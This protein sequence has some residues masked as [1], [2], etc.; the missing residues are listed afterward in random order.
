LSALFSLFLIHGAFA[1]TPSTGEII[2]PIPNPVPL[3]DEN[4]PSMFFGPITPEQA[5]AY[6]SELQRLRLE[7]P[8]AEIEIPDPAPQD[9]IA[10][11]VPPLSWTEPDGSVHSFAASS[12]LL[13][14]I[15]EQRQ[16][17]DAL[18]TLEIPTEKRLVLAALM[19][20]ISRQGILQ[21]IVLYSQLVIYLDGIGADECD[22]APSAC[23]NPDY[24][25]GSTSQKGDLS[26]L[27]HAGYDY[28]PSVMWD[29]G[30]YKMWWCSDGTLTGDHIFYAEST[31]L[32]SWTILANGNQ[33][34]VFS[35]SYNPA[36]DNGTK[37]KFDSLLTCDPSVVKVGGTYFMYYT[38]YPRNNGTYSFTTRIGAAYSYDGKQW[39][40]Y[41]N[42]VAPIINTHVSGVSVFGTPPHYGVGHP[43]VVY[44]DGFF[45][46]TYNDSSGASGGGTTQY[47]LRS[48]DPFFQVNVEEWRTGGVWYRLNGSPGSTGY[49]YLNPGVSVDWAYSPASK[50]FVISV[51]GAG[52]TYSSG[53]ESGRRGTY[54]SIRVFNKALTSQRDLT[55][56][57]AQWVDGP[58]IVKGPSGHMLY[59]AACEN[60]L[61]RV[62]RAGR[63]WNDP[64]GIYTHSQCETNYH[65]SLLPPPTP[66]PTPDPRHIAHQ[67]MIQCTELAYEGWDMD[68][69]VT[70]CNSL[71]S[72]SLVQ[73]ESDDDGVSDPVVWRP[74]TG[75]WWSK[76]ST[77]SGE[78]GE[79]WGS[80]TAQPIFGADY[81]GDR[82]AD[83][84]VKEGPHFRVRPS[85]G[86]CPYPFVPYVGTKG[87]TWD[88]GWATADVPLPGDYD[89]DGKTDMAV[90]I[91]S[92][93]KFQYIRTGGACRSSYSA[94]NISGL[95]GCERSMG[96]SG[97]K[98]IVADYDGD[99]KADFSYVYYSGSNPAQ[100]WTS[101]IS[102]SSCPS[103]FSSLFTNCYVQLA[104]STDVVVTADLNDDGKTDI[105]WWNAADYTFRTRESSSTTCPENFGHASG[106]CSLAMGLSGDVPL[107]KQFN[108]NTKPEPVVWRPSNGTW[109]VNRTG[110]S[111]PIGPWTFHYASGPLYIHA[112]QWGLSSDKVEGLR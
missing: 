11:P 19:S 37:N 100:I 58:G 112:S 99:G 16:S 17:H 111:N 76:R 84:A 33:G 68:S 94:V 55:H 48:T 108:G 27:T 45:Y 18:A 103:G 21:S 95:G 29:E 57:R 46:I 44:L 34:I 26:V 6:S 5:Q 107:G 49:P 87:C 70:G 101:P 88:T 32:T 3:G 80:A 62:L 77:N 105:A 73:D 35:P 102:G 110:S 41:N 82:I 14:F 28:V 74:S 63:D 109:Y 23:R 104:A 85:S 50:E 67:A 83:L 65:S 8:D 30:K 20:A 64:K 93:A 53:G 42:G 56:V 25:Q 2:Q 43:S 81:D 36:D 106:I 24:G 78:Q 1:E 90:R 15:S 79:Q 75:T 61:I 97:D 92:P 60:F 12:S 98:P 9:P 47:A 71:L 72:T 66:M 89:G 7:N 4:L 86:D 91:N 54:S 39:F 52:R 69:G 13:R 59:D 96:S 40:R 31:T 22:S 51:D 10:R 38:A